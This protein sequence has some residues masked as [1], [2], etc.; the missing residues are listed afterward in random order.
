MKLLAIVGSLRQK[1][2][3]STLIQESL[4]PWYRKG[5][6]PRIIY[7]GDYDIK[8]CN[9]CEGCRKTRQCII[10]DDMHQLYRL[11]LDADAVLLGSPTYFYTVTARMKV[12]IDR[13]YC[14]VDFAD[15]DRSVWIG[16]VETKGG[17]YASV[18]SV[19]E[20]HSPD[21]MGSTYTVME[22]SLQALG[23]RVV[24]GVKAYGLF[25]PDEATRDACALEQARKAGEK[26]LR[27]VQLRKSIE[28]KSIVNSFSQI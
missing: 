27:T 15:D 26:L 4:K 19:C 6:E 24:S 8:P 17:K 1:G 18:I 21:D 16:A 28:Q 11:L 22:K 14:L 23:F 2:N 20:Q 5:L 9:G 3:T 13:C 25:G 10:E 7:L 12:F